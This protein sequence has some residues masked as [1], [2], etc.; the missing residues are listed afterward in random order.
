MEQRSF[1]EVVSLAGV[2]VLAALTALTLALVSYTDLVIYVGLISVFVHAVSQA[3]GQLYAAIESLGASCDAALVFVLAVFSVS[4]ATAGDALARDLEDGGM[5]GA[6][7]DGSAWYVYVVGAS[8]ISM[9]AV[10]LSPVLLFV[11]RYGFIRWFAQQRFVAAAL[12]VAGSPAVRYITFSVYCALVLLLLSNAYACF[13]LLREAGLAAEEVV[14]FLVLYA[15]LLAATFTAAFERM[16]NLPLAPLLQRAA[17][18]PLLR[19]L[20]YETV[21]RT[22][23]SSNVPQLV[24]AWADEA[25]RRAERVLAA[26]AAT[27]RAAL[28]DVPFGRR[29]RS[30]VA[31]RQSAALL[32]AA[33]EWRGECAMHR[34]PR[35]AAWTAETARAASDPLSVVHRAV[36]LDDALR[37][38]PAAVGAA[39]ARAIGHVRAEADDDEDDG[40]DGEAHGHAHRGTLGGAARELAQRVEAALEQAQLAAR[41]LG[42]TTERIAHTCAIAFDATVQAWALDARDT[43]DVRDALSQ[44]TDRPR[45]PAPRAFRWWGGAGGDVDRAG[46][47]AAR[48]L[49]AEEALIEVRVAAQEL[50]AAAAALNELD[51]LPAAA[52]A[53]VALGGAAIARALELAHDSASLAKYDDALALAERMA[54]SAAPD[55]GASGAH[56][57]KRAAGALGERAEG[58]W[59]RVGEARLALARTGSSAA[60]AKAHVKGGS[61]KALALVQRLQT[62]RYVSIPEYRYVYLLY[63]LA[64]LAEAARR[65]WLLAAWALRG[66]LRVG[67]LARAI[68]IGAVVL[69]ALLILVHLLVAFRALG[70]QI[71]GQ[72]AEA[73]T[74]NAVEK[75]VVRAIGGFARAARSCC[76]PRA[77]PAGER[78]MLPAPDGRV[79]DAANAVAHDAVPPPQ[80]VQPRA[81]AGQSPTH[82][83]PRAMKQK[84]RAAA[85]VRAA[86]APPDRARMAA[87]PPDA[88]AR[89]APRQAAKISLPAARAPRRRS[90]TEEGEAAAGSAIER[91]P[92]SA[93]P[94]RHGQGHEQE[95][96]AADDERKLAPVQARTSSRQQPVH[97]RA[98]MGQDEEKE[99]AKRAEPGAAAPPER[100]ALAIIQPAAMPEPGAGRP[101]ALVDPGRARGFTLTPALRALVDALVELAL[102][103]AQTDQGADA[104][105]KL[106]AELVRSRGALR[107]ALASA[108]SQMRAQI[109]EGTVDHGARASPSEDIALLDALDPWVWLLRLAELF[110]RA[111]ADLD[112]D[113]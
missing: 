33:S 63:S 16:M 1:E 43:E 55:F 87:P 32:L 2:V 99:G 108:V 36:L 65:T 5:L 64:S 6:D 49:A 51:D 81:R 82:V 76:A 57:L 22:T 18:L 95:Q 24:R 112:K 54:E 88:L 21:L 50:S 7:G 42:E 100:A 53:L 56:A 72:S 40:D 17:T 4:L 96:G 23:V 34:L 45:L 113:A 73:P 66:T 78:A 103:Q 84:A 109:V 61:A 25:V 58:A 19:A 71:H 70:G 80:R 98:L 27:A 41:T 59:G 12:R 28:T 38:L 3:V 37:T 35:L 15:I 105:D 44:E 102:A 107:D 74:A 104:A 101:R 94:S 68:G 46:E 62:R 77:L 110:H 91:K 13:Q 10:G 47:K 69:S 85:P 39:R 11:P 111:A 86:A 20:R 67:W 60:A 97:E 14:L 29:P 79:V 9:L 26:T 30:E 52:R 75:L 90:R 89:L 93:P 83:A 8:H 106:R 48:A 31:A 92:A